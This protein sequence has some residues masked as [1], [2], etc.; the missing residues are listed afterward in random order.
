[1]MNDEDKILESLN[2][3]QKEAVT[4]LDSP[5][6]IIAGAGSGKTKVITHKIAYLIRQKKYSP[7]N[8]LGV[9][10]T[11]KAANEMKTRV[12]TLTGIDARFFNISTFHSF[13]LR[14]L[15]EC[16]PAAGFDKN[17]Q[18]IDDQD[19]KK[20]L[21][22]II[23]ENLSYYTSDM[24]DDA[25]KKIN[26]AKMDLHYPNNKEF[27]FQKGFSED[28]VKIFTLYFDFQRENKVWDYEDLVSLP[29]KLLQ[30]NEAV[31]LRY[32]EKFRYVM[33]DEFQDTNPNQYELLRLIAGE[34]KNIAVVGDDDQAI[35]SWRGASIRYL[36]H[37]EED[38]PGAHIIKL[39]QNYRS[40]PQVLDFANS[41]INKN[42]LRRP[43]AMWTEKQKGNPVYLI[44]TRSKEEEAESAAKYIMR[45]KLER[46]EFFPAAV[47]YRINSQ[48]LPFETEFTKWGID[49]KIIKG[50]RFFERKEIKDS[51]ALLKLAVNPDDDVSFLRL[52]DFLP[53]GIGPKT[54]DALDAQAKKKNLSLF[55]TLRETMPDRFKA[56][57]IFS[58]IYSIFTQAQKQE[59]PSFSEILSLLLKESGYMESL[60]SRGEQGRLLNV[61]ELM[62]FIKKWEMENPD[63]TPGD[64][65][66]R[67]S[68]E[69]QPDTAGLL[70]CPVFLLTMHNA[71]GLEFPTVF[72]TGVNSSYV[73]FF[74]SKEKS[75]IEEERRLFYVAATRAIRQ[76]VISVGSEKP[77]R[78]LSDVKRSLY[79]SVFTVEGLFSYL[80]TEERKPLPES[81]IAQAVVEEK[82]L[83]HPIFGRG[84][85]INALGSDKYV[86]DFVKKG[87]KVIDASIVP[88]TFL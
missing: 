27:L 18:V 31:R 12:E 73:P 3:T 84:K 14:I 26:F 64:L 86:V 7:A 43:K 20:I 44:N 38:F 1:M 69:P 77:S 21:D 15:R 41:L 83:E 11:N 5:L 55:S 42:T 16:S 71:K 6:L 70:H 10:F 54:L 87:E 72:V 52:I 85:I 78:F 17:W 28:E 60:E 34:H 66:D 19:Q 74:M 67:I 51:L 62:E 39:Q 58:H 49:F 35:Y 61:R 65:M 29:A 23:K 82:Y 63:E 22:R 36:F 25:R 53:L 30:S 40:T 76:L 9:T 50:L 37:F 80:E 24:R 81:G 75:E 13:G 8:I 88:V 32:A 79:S 59:R 2:P 57:K 47:L 68:L 4:Y 46:P 33:V 56:K 48:S 45:L